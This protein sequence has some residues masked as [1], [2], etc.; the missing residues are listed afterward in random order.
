MMSVA[1]TRIVVMAGVGGATLLIVASLF[2]VS[3]RDVAE[4]AASDVAGDYAASAA[5]ER[6]QYIANTEPLRPDEMRVISLGTGMPAAN[7]GQAA[8]SFLVQLGNG[9]NFIFDIGTNAYGNLTSLQI[10]AS[11]LDKVFLGHLHFDHIGDLSALLIAAVSHGRN[12]PL[13][14]WGPSGAAPDLGT[15]YAVERLLEAFNWEFTSKR[16]KI[17]GAGYQAVVTEFDYTKTQVVYEENGVRIMAWPAI[18]AIDGPV[19][20][21]LEWN[22]LKFVYSS[23]T[24]PNR[25]FMENG[26]DADILIHETFPTVQ[27][28]IERNRMVP[29]SAWPVGTRIHTQPAAAGKV[30][31]ILNPRMAVTFHF[32]STFTTRKEVRDEVRTTYDGPLTVGKDLLVWNVTPDKVTVREA[33]VPD[34]VWP[35]KSKL[36]SAKYD[37]SEAIFPSDWLNE[38]RLDLS[39]IDAAIWSRLAP[40]IRDRIAEKLPDARP[41]SAPK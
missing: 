21:S 8:S 13:R 39:D 14:I 11:R 3:A 25:W 7:K 6:D 27:Q 12:V 1:S 38:G 41:R 17:P 32:V 5:E 36:E 31:S 26:E 35:S 2:L 24:Y 30:F 22:G 19:S 16:G 4:A 9:E 10:P 23:D 18:H 15:R 20:Y 28:L 29:E 33:L 37:P 40:E 34:V